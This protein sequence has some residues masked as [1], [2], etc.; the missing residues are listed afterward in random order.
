MS[1]ARPSNPERFAPRWRPLAWVMQHPIPAGMDVAPGRGA[2]RVRPG[3]RPASTAGRFPPFRGARG[4][5]APR[6]LAVLVGRISFW[7]KSKSPLATKLVGGYRSPLSGRFVNSGLPFLVQDCRWSKAYRPANY[8]VL[9]LNFLHETGCDGTGC[10]VGV[11]AD[12]DALKFVSA[13][14]R[15]H[16]GHADHEPS[17]YRPVASHGFGLAGRVKRPRVL[18]ALPGAVGIVRSSN[19]ETAY[20]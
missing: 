5:F 14:G 3:R 9:L 18:R 6:F 7:G 4:R 2:L 10:V 17:P 1:S 16:V 11:R 19:L 15:G 12:D 8:L 13:L 20:G